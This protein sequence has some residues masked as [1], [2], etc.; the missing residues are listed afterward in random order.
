MGRSVVLHLAAV[1]KLLRAS[2]SSKWR[3]ACYRRLYLGLY[4]GVTTFGTRFVY[5]FHRGI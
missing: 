4:A 2:D 3:D 5:R 1:A